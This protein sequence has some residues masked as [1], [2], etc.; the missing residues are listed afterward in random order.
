MHWGICMKY[1]ARLLT[2]LILLTM[3][4]APAYAGSIR[5]YIGDNT[6]K[7]YASASSSS[8]KLG[9]LGYGE[10][11]RCIDLD[12][13]WAKIEV[14]S[15]Q[16]WCKV[17]ALTTDDPN[18]GDLTAYIIS[19][20]AKAYSLPSSS[21]NSTDVAEGTKVTVVAMTPDRD[22][23]RVRKSGDYAY[24]KTKHLTT[25]KP[26]TKS[27][28][29]AKPETPGNSIAAYINDETV[30]I[31]AAA[32]S[33]ASRV[34]TA[35][36]GEKVICTSVSGSWAQVEYGDITGWCSKSKL[37]TTDPN[38]S[39]QTVYAAK[40]GTEVYAQP[41]SSEV[42]C[43]IGTTTG[44]KCVATTPDGKWM[45]VTASG[46][47]GYVKKSE[48]TTTKS[49]SKI[50]KLIDLALEQLGKPYVYATRGTKSFDCSGL[51]L[52]CYREIYNITLGRSAKSQGYNE[53]YAKIESMSDVK[54]GDIVC[55]NTVEDDED[56]TDHVGIY[57]GD[58][59]FIHASS[60]K[61]EVMI[62]TMSSGY[63]K[64][65]FVWARRLVE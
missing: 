46:K 62:S 54:K 64:R 57:I 3:F 43:T 37:T 17:D 52:Y 51:T 5:V 13:D 29:P 4:A 58:G 48:M 12:G 28:T 60:A 25:E 44:L 56:L 6:L 9:T 1:I 36:Y 14:G 11:A 53:K 33:S 42:I 27:E 21:A 39:S 24:I 8:S 15:V 50:D 45:R 32:S 26:E 41:A 19:G 65:T 61:G 38:T 47:Y 63:Y 16:A 22:W 2:A 7:Y 34:A 59:K 10:K 31:Y 55:F 30:K 40:S 23:C 35:A 20:G 18:T 49:D